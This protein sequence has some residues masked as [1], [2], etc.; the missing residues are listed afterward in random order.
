[1]G[2]LGPA[3]TFTEQALLTQADLAA[4][5]RVPL[6]S[7]AAVLAA[8][9]AGDVDLGFVAIEN[10]IEGTVAVTLDTLVF[11]PGELLVQREVVTPVRLHLLAPPGV[12]LGDVTR[13]VS[14]PHATAQ[15]RGFLD[16][17]LPGAVTAAADSTAEAARLVA[18]ERDGRSAAIGTER[19]AALYG[20]DVLAAAVEDHPA[21][22]TRFVLVARSGVPAP[23]GR[24]TTT[25]VVFPRD[26][27]PGSLLAILQEFAT[28]GIDLTRLESRP[29]RRA[30]GD[31]C[32]VVDVR[33]HVADP[34]VADCLRELRAHQADVRFLGSYPA[35][36]PAGG[37]W[38]TG[39]PGAAG[40]AGE[41]VDGDGGG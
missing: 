3:G 31:Y 25:V 24:D 16:E 12:G 40:E 30:L 8:V 38:L 11:G 41:A 4:A 29:T 18:E 36:G 32:F 13:V 7:I 28:R 37:A 14:F 27:R 33:G 22:A 9:A 15:C 39:S 26:D 17:R 21:N 23:T 20:L 35:A 19:A 1:M 34:V 6:P 5:E 2:F 10:A